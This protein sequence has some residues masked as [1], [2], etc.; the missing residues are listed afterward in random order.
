MPALFLMP[1][2]NSIFFSHFYF[3]DD[4]VNLNLKLQKV[5]MYSHL[6]KRFNCKQVV[7][8]KITIRF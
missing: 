4:P 7:Y 1:L 6:L 5:F 3:T 8:F 2:L